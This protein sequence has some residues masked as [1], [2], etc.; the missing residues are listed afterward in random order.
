[1]SIVIVVCNQDSFQIVYTMRFLKTAM[2]NLLVLEKLYCYSSSIIIVGIVKICFTETELN[3]FFQFF[4]LSTFF[5][6]AHKALNTAIGIVLN[7]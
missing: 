5:C 1:M 4:A 7:K 3:L 6:F 2:I